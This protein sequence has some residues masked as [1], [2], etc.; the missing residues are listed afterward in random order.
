MDYILFCFFT[1]LVNQQ[2]AKLAII[3]FL[4]LATLGTLF[5]EISSN[6]KNQGQNLARK[7]RL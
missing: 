2:F 1:W 4:Y 5:W 3:L 6:K 7:M